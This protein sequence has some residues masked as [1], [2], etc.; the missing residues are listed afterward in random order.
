MLKPETFVRRTSQGLFSNQ[1]DPV[2]MIHGHWLYDDYINGLIGPMKKNYS[3]PKII[4][5]AENCIKELKNE[6]DKYANHNI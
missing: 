4:Q 5:G 6:F 1:G 3:D 2:Y